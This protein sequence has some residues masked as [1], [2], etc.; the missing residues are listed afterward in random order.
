MR[1]LEIEELKKSCP[2]K[3][4]H[5]IPPN[6]ISLGIADVDF[7]GP[8]GIIDFIKS[9][10]SNDFSFYQN[11]SGLEPALTAASQF[12][13]NQKR[14]ESSLENIQIIEGTMMGIFTA[15]K[16]ISEYEGEL[17]ILNPVYEPIHRH[18]TDNKNKINWVQFTE[19]GLD[20]DQLADSVNKN[21][22]MIV[23]CNPVNPTG[24][25]FDKSRLY[26]RKILYFSKVF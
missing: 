20:L 25:V 17:A 5:E 24:H 3:W 15:M 8:N 18:A 19:E 6:G 13:N 11:Q 23:M 26:T 9:N 21:T 14:V 22:K 12:L 1:L 10:L 16:W 2:L 7:E 4:H